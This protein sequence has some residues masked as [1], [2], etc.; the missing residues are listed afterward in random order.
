[1]RNFKGI[2]YQMDW[3]A[4]N[5]GMEGHPDSKSRSSKKIFCDRNY[6]RPWKSKVC[7]Y[8]C[9]FCNCSFLVTAENPINPLYQTKL[10]FNFHN[11]SLTLDTIF[12]SPGSFPRPLSFMYAPWV[13]ERVIFLAG[14]ISVWV[15]PAAV[16]SV[17]P[18]S[19]W[20]RRNERC[21]QCWLA[22]GM[23]LEWKVARAS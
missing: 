20:G 15:R 21:I 22:V 18:L 2:H 3:W 16:T 14:S 9:D 13:K 17:R 10:C 1:M 8:H 12:Y 6:E 4:Y 7:C 19:Q 11:K 23:D 5:I